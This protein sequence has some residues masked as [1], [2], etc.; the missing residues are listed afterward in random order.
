MTL[1]NR[2][3]STFATLQ[4]CTATIVSSAPFSA[5]Q[6]AEQ[7]GWRYLPTN[8]QAQDISKYRFTLL[9][10]ISR[11]PAHGPTDRMADGRQ[12]AALPRSVYPISAGKAGKAGG[13]VKC[14]PR[15]NASFVEWLTGDGRYRIGTVIANDR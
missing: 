11:N 10:T 3:S 6:N 8:C 12:G 7:G 13:R 2:P 4:C 5:E 9:R 14:V 1:L 15:H